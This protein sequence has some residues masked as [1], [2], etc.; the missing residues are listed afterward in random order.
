MSG[1]VYECVVSGV[2]VWGLGGGGW[3]TIVAPFEV[4]S[5]LTRD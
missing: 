2:C 1:C 3:W 5:A 4:S